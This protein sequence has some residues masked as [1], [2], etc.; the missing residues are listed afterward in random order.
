M[1]SQQRLL[2][3][4]DDEGICRLLSAILKRR[5]YEVESCL[6]GGA[7][8][9]RLRGGGVSL[10]V[11]D[12]Y[13]PD[14]NGQDLVKMLS[15]EGILPPYIVISGVDDVRVAV[16]LMQLG[17]L[18]F[19]PKDA[20]MPAMVVPVVKRCFSRLEQD[21]KLREIETRFLQLAANIES[22][23]WIS[24]PDMRRFLYLSPAYEK[25]WG[26]PVEEAY[27]HAESLAEA[28]LA[29]DAPALKAALKRLMENAENM[30]IEFRIVR[31]DGEMRWLHGTAF[32]L[33]DSG[34]KV[35]RLTGF[36]HDITER[37]ELSRRLL[38]AADM[39]RRR[40]GAD[41][42]DD[43]CQRL[44]AAKLQ[45]GL[46]ERQLIAE[47][48]KAAETAAEL[49]SAVTE[50]TALSRS[51]AQGLAPVLLDSEG[52][53]PSLKNLARSATKI[54]GIPVIFEDPVTAPR[55]NPETAN[56]VY[57][58]A[59]EL[60]SNAAKHASPSRIAVRLSQ[61]SCCVA[62]QVINDGIA[63]A[64]DLAGT[65]S[66]GMG[67]H[68]VRLRTEAMG[69]TLD[70]HPGQEPDGGTRAV[71]LIPNRVSDHENPSS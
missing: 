4:D 39:E 20:Q 45:S 62:L 70:F 21:S 41:L 31:P 67:L 38:E 40:V 71:C 54:F 17:A 34:G 7:A 2:I 15:E 9:E 25:I 30:E 5:G 43:L 8:L 37:K 44:A 33:F 3:V 58:I 48:S 59:Q 64:P 10:L 63:F 61:D 52:I 47:G 55:T 69:A 19:L 27:G 50:A 32:P 16:K 42:H 18:D 6:S 23:F 36:F 35:E 57:R 66:F 24:S 11:L 1:Q 53:I 14:M 29:L 12:L 26:L 49:R 51:L 46:L 22:V 56:H 68:L 28:V 65:G 60:I 13:L